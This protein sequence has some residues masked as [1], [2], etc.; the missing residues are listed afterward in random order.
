MPL[1]KCVP[2]LPKEPPM[3][4]AVRAGTDG[5]LIHGLLH[6]IINEKLYDEDFVETDPGLFG[7]C[8]Y[9]QKLI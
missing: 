1:I 2:I 8:D 3:V 6:V 9:V 5:A 4:A 7:L